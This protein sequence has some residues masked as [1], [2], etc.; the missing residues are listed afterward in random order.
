M[1][2][3]RIDLLT[4]ILSEINSQF[5]LQICRQL[6][7]EIGEIYSEMTDFKIAVAEQE[8]RIFTVFFVQGRVKKWLDFRNI[9]KMEI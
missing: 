6:Q 4:P 9:K 3:R 7:Y 2:K 5:Y 1:H 8:G